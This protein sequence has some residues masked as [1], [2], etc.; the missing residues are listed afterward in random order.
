MA[1]WKAHGQL[2]IRVN[3]TF[4]VIYY[5]SGA[6]RRNVYSS[7]VFTGVDLLALNFYPDHNRPDQLFLMPQNHKHD[8][9]GRRRPHPSVF[10]RFDTIPE[11]V[12][13]MDRQMDRWTARR[14]CHSIYVQPLAKLPRC[15]NIR[16]MFIASKLHNTH[17]TQN[18]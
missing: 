7:A 3:I 18:N 4:F 16:K 1:Y 6:T 15:K 5:G 2:F 8:P 13:Q 11:C 12:G 17:C 9:T 14:I 10:R